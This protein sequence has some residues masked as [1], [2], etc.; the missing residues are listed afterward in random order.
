MIHIK[1]FIDLVNSSKNKNQTQ[2]IITTK[3]A[4]KISYDLGCLMTEYIALQK[5]N[6]ELK[7]QKDKVNVEMDAVLTKHE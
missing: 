5:E 4:E 7:N 3:D 2:I 1:K 6:T